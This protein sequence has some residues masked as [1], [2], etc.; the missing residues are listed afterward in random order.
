MF[1]GNIN[2]CLFKC[3]LSEHFIK[4]D[5]T[6]LLSQMFPLKREVS[7]VIQHLQVRRR[8]VS[9]LCV[10]VLA[11]LCLYVWII[12]CKS[13]YGKRQLSLLMTIC[14]SSSLTVSPF[15]S[16]SSLRC[17]PFSLKT[18]FTGTLTSCFYKVTL[19]FASFE[20]DTI[21]WHCLFFPHFLVHLFQSFKYSMSRDPLEQISV[22]QTNIW[23]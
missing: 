21:S 3:M 14:Q 23:V 6:F 1:C 18:S 16:L 20:C 15:I 13:H 8:N 2:N 11:R 9:R 5:C 22:A 7:L 4:L 19:A 10:L 17:R 12:D